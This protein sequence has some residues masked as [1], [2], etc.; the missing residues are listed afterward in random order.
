LHQARAVAA[1]RQQTA[2]QPRAAGGMMTAYNGPPAGLPDFPQSSAYP[3]P[4]RSSP[5]RPVVPNGPYAADAT[6]VQPVDRLPV[7]SNAAL[8]PA[9][10]PGG[11][12]PSTEL[13]PLPPIATA[14]PSADASNNPSAA[15]N[16]AAST[17]PADAGAAGDHSADDTPSADSSVP[18]EQTVAVSYEADQPDDWPGHVDSAIQILEKAKKNSPEDEI[19]LR[20]LY[21]AAERYED[22][23]RSVPGLT[24]DEQTFWTTGFH[25]MGTLL[26]SKQNPDLPS[27]T[28]EAKHILSDAT[29][30]LGELAPLIVR[31]LAF[32]TRVHSYGCFETFGSYRFAPEQ[33]VL[34]YAE[35]DNFAST[36]TP[37]GHH[38]SLRSSYQ[39]FDARGQRVAEQELASTEE[40]CQNRRQHGVLSGAHRHEGKGD[41]R[42]AQPCV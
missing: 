14:A 32:C 29:A 8:P 19:R 35:V 24:P 22:A 2:Q 10:A 39:L 40:F 31:N 34:L 37:R 6:E 18:Q 30:K 20:M 9:S 36:S 1:Y 41:L 15:M 13:Q 26:N 42:P 4:E 38:T 3:G 25:G 16:P 12:Y 21:M 27:R 33:R 28:A 7:S 17:A 5:L 11:P 23:I